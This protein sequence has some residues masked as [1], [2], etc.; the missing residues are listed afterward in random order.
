MSSVKICGNV[1]ESDIRTAAMAGADF[2]GVISHPD[3]ERGHTVNTDTAARLMEYAHELPAKTEGVLLPR[4]TDARK[5]RMV[6][7]NVRP[8]WLQI[9]EVEDPK[10]LEELKQYEPDMPLI[11][12]L[13]VGPGLIERTGAFIGLADA[14]LFDTAGR[15]PGGNGVPHDWRESA[16]AIEVVRGAGK[17]SILAGGLSQWNVLK[18]IRTAKPDIVDAESGIKNAEDITDLALSVDFVRAAHMGFQQLNVIRRS[19]SYRARAE[20]VR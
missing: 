12:V 4:L 17:K 10:L 11:Q 3:Y 20:A 7:R 14:I 16:A 13:H 18:A 5:I 8:D 15:N 2:V 6:A 19:R 1:C 9:G